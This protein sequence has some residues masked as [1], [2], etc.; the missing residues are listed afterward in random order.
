MTNQEEQSDVRIARLEEKLDYLATAI[1][2]MSVS[3]ENLKNS[4]VTREEF[5]NVKVVVMGIANDGGLVRRVD[6]IEKK[7]IYYA[8]I[9]FLA[10]I[11]ILGAWQYFLA[12]QPQRTSTTTT[13]TTTNNTSK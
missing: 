13:N 9:T 1:E 3:L 12:T 6:K 2:R 5:S 4:F 11:I 7:F 10:G 8:G